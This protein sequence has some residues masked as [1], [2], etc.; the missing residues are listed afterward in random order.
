MNIVQFTSL[1]FIFSL[2][3]PCI[4][5]SAPV[6]II[7]VEGNK[8]SRIVYAAEFLNIYDHSSSLNALMNT[9]SDTEFKKLH[10]EQKQVK[11]RVIAIYENNKSP[12][13]TDM[14]AEFICF[15]KQYRVVSA[16][17]MIRD[18]SEKFPS[19]D[20]K[21]FS[22]AKSAWPM[23]ASKIACEN[24]LVKK[25]ATQVAASKNGQDFSAFDQLGLIYIGNLDRLQVVD[26]AWESVLA[27]GNR[28]AY[29]NKILTAQEKK[30]WND[31][32]DKQLAEA[33]KQ[34]AGYEALATAELGNIKAEQAF[35]KEIGKNSKKH[36]KQLKW[37][38]G[39]TEAE[40]VNMSGTPVNLA[41]ADGERYLTYFNEYFITGVSAYRD[42]NG[43]QVN[44]GTTVTC[45]L[46]IQLRQGGSKVDFRVIDYQLYATNGGCRDLSWFNKNNQ[47]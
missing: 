15:K 14:T 17:S 3:L 45:E 8:P 24:E 9:Q 43:N 34:A 40:I 26:T 31:K 7:F 13:S 18:G 2:I 6:G 23:I 19:H 10:D 22:Y 28:P 29:K 16:H 32:I 44:G 46:K 1:F 33:K 37:I 30:E 12:E 27:D 20:W 36:G 21:P 39:K 4:S 47:L 42:G 38:I 41:E 5:F 35:K 11:M 25:A